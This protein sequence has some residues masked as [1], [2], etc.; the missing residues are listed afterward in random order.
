MSQQDIISP[1]RHI[2][3]TGGG[4][5]GHVIPCVPIIK[6][7]R[8]RGWVISYIGSTSGLES[9]LLAN[10]QLDY[11]GISTGKLRR[12]FSFKNV[13]D[14][15]RILLGLCQA[16]RILGKQKP[17][18]VF[19]KGGYVSLPVVFSAWLRN[20]PVIA[21]E[22]DVTPGLANRLAL[23]FVKKVCVNFEDTQLEKSVY[24]G[25]PLRSELLNGSVIAGRKLAGLAD[26]NSRQ[27]LLVVGGSLGATRINQV[28][29]DSLAELLP[30]FQ[31]VHVC[32]PGKRMQLPPDSTE[33]KGY[34]QFEF[35]D[36]GWGDLLAAADVIVS[37]AGANAVY[38]MLILH[39]LNLLIPLSREA[40][41]GDQLINAALM[42]K[43]GFSRVIQE[44][45]LSSQVL[46]SNLDNMMG[47]REAL[48][49]RMNAFETPDSLG[50]I[51][52]LLEKHANLAES[53]G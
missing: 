40:S 43:Q 32:G 12:Y 30:R 51:V 35:V 26:N 28:V 7:F 3:F 15:F 33:F 34:V 8:S 22:S 27:I 31:V 16:Y 24:T 50:R 17:D 36:Q 38:E 42:E 21:H 53:E 20:I 45:A 44:D 19:S 52:S 48:Q 5:G 4:T 39:K 37:R 2:L 29:R 14:I 41:R 18:I 46:I 10:L 1:A 47:E 25:T 9:S 11:F 23:P 49:A 6:Y 13:S